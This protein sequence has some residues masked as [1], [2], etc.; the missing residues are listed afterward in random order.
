VLSHVNT[1]ITC[2]IFVLMH[3]NTRNEIYCTEMHKDFFYVLLTVHIS[4]FIVV[5]NHLN[6]QNVCLQYV[7][8]T[9]LHVSSIYVHHQEVKI[10]LHSLWYHHTE[11]SEWSKITKIHSINM[12]T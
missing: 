12:S 4:I 1:E 7:Y 9:S 2:K 3:V 6:A 10:V 5:I 8:Y 11:T